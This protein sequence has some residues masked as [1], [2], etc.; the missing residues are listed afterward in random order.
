MTAAL[1][2]LFAGNQPS[3]VSCSIAAALRA[4]LRTRNSVNASCG[5]FP[6]EN[7][8]FAVISA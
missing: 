1:R 4:A 8:G 5:R 6:A 3:A 7:N 2:P